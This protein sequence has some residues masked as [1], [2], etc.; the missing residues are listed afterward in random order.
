MLTRVKRKPADT[1]ARQ[2]SFLLFPSTSASKSGRS[3]HI[4][5][6]CCD[7]RLDYQ[8]ES[9]HFPAEGM[10]CAAFRRGP[11]EMISP[12]LS[13]DFRGAGRTKRSHPLILNSQNSANAVL[14]CK[15]GRQELITEAP[16]R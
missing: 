7:R 6:C 9:A 11:F 4:F 8:K 3:G 15:N 13:N 16:K 12:A 2:A 14:E 1:Y 10:S 5:G